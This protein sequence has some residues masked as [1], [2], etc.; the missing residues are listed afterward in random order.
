MIA[1]NTTCI[2]P[3]NF[4]LDIS[5]AYGIQVNHQPNQAKSTGDYYLTILAHPP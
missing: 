2:E 1:P 3:L 5:P 4:C